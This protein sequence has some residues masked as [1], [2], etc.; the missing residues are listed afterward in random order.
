MVGFSHDFL[1]SFGIELSPGRWREGFD[2]ITNFNEGLNLTTEEDSV[3]LSI[4]YEHGS[5]SIGI[6]ACVEHVL[7]SIV[8]QDCKVSI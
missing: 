7:I 4:S 2:L 3:L 5:N 8:Y 6:S 1:T